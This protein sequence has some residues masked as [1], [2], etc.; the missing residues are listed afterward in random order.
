MWYKIALFLHVIGALLLCTALVIEWLC[1]LNLRKA[2]TPERIRESVFNYSALSKIGGTAMLLILIPGFYMT[3]MVWKDASW[4]MIALAGLLL[5]GII[6]GVV[7][8]RKMNK[9]KKM[10][11]TG[12]NSVQ[13]FKPL[14]NKNSLW[15][16][17]Q[18][19]TFLFLGIIFL[20]TVKPGLA[21]SITAIL[22]SILV[23]FL[24]LRRISY[25]GKG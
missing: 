25:K 11:K 21:G 8:G 22:I 12:N 16:S 3:A 18:I 6:G 7:T 9:I 14:L 5:L 15:L 13:E 4:I 24:P 17:I 2:D 10:V 1:I 20:M 23:G 19:R